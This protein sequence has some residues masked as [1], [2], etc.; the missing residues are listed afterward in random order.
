[1][2]PAVRLLPGSIAEMLASAS[3]T[4]M[5]TKADQHG[6]QAAVL[7]ETLSD[8]EIRAVNRLLRGIKRGKIKV[9]DNQF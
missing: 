1:M 5:L 3:Q 4:G 7:E 6:L 8:E 9:V 2:L